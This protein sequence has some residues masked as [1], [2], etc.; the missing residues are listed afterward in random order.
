MRFEPKTFESLSGFEASRYA[1][2]L[3]QE[4]VTEEDLLE[5][6][7]QTIATLDLPHLEVVVFLLA[8]V[9]TNAAWQMVGN[10]LDHPNFSIRF[11]AIKAIRNLVSL[12]ETLMRRVVACLSTYGGDGLADEL[13][14]LLD[15]PANAEA[16]RVVQEFRARG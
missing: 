8:S 13:G 1:M 11:V 16:R 7:R 14:K 15:R 3:V 5:Y 2:R 9:G 12:D 10:Y 6:F 4:G